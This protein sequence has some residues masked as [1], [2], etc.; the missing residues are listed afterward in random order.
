MPFTPKEILDTIP[1]SRRLSRL[2]AWVKIYTDLCAP[3]WQDTVLDKDVLMHC[4]ESYF[5]DL[6]RT[7]AFHDI[8]L[9]DQHKQAAFTIKWIVR[10]RPIFIR[11]GGKS[12]KASL[13]ANE[14][15]ALAAGLFWLRAKPGDLSEPFL[16]NLLYTLHYRN[17]DPEVMATM[18]YTVECA[19]NGKKP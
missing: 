12:T 13:L 10:T 2:H 3:H 16:R 9:A 11:P 17:F 8:S 6:E 7:K 18:M 4:V 14:M 1:E 19:L 5:C 15:F